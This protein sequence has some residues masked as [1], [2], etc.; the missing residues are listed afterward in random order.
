MISIDPSSQM[1][2]R[3]LACMFEREL[4][5]L[6]LFL[7][8]M[9]QFKT[10]NYRFKNAIFFYDITLHCFHL[11]GGWGSCERV[12][13]VE[14][15]EA[16][17]RLHGLNATTAYIKNDAWWPPYCSYHDYTVTRGENTK[18]ESIK[19]KEYHLFFNENVDGNTA[20]CDPTCVCKNG[21]VSM[22]PLKFEYWNP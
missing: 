3:S 13:T 8:E 18:G 22:Y 15:C 10:S 7:C 4:T 1:K 19:V 9:M 2:A 12:T 11:T 16:H 21:L 17:A 20:P 14:E 5:P 6:Y